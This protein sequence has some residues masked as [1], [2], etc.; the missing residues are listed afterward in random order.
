MKKISTFALLLAS[1]LLSSCSTTFYQVYQ[2]D[3]DQ[4]DVTDEAI[5]YENDDCSVLYN[6]WSNGGNMSFLF[7]NKTGKSLY[8]IMSES[9]YIQN[10]E[11][12]DYY[13]EGSETFTTSYSVSEA[14]A[15]S[16][17]L[18][19][20]VNVGGKWYNGNVAATVVEKKGMT[21]SKSV[22]N[23]NPKVICIPPYSSK[24]ITSFGILNQAQLICDNPKMN[25]PKMTAKVGGSYSKD[26]SPLTFR[27]RIAYTTDPDS[28]DFHFIDNSFWVSSYTNYSTKAATENIKV[29]RCN[30]SN[31]K[32]ISNNGFEMNV[33]KIDNAHSFYNSYKK[34]P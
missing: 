31:R 1:I 11:A 16:A 14:A 15:A 27:N 20:K 22:T 3:S 32:A 19:G 26:N 23:I 13:K 18:L 10:G 12:R 30:T 5:V 28:R 24:Y 2:V 6:L 4:M 8:L 21:S 25:Y 34:Q 7:T 17:T 9:F 29:E 33:F